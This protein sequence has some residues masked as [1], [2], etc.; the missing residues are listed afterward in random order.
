MRCMLETQRLG[1]KDYRI[2]GEAGDANAAGSQV[3]IFC[4]DSTS[5]AYADTDI[6]M[7]AILR[8]ISVPH[9]VIM[10]RRGCFH[11][12]HGITHST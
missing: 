5:N 4:A 11:V 9:I 7:S 8:C 2:L 12:N 10:G 3:R 1:K 6:P